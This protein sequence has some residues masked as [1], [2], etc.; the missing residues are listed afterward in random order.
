MPKAA[1]ARPPPTRQTR[2]KGRLNFLYPGWLPGTSTLWFQSE[3]SGYGH[4]Y[5]SDGGAARAV[6]AGKWEASDVEVG[7]DGRSFWFLCNRNWPG[8]YEC[9]RPAAPCAR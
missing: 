8:D 4:I 6:T 9:R 5:L 7:R 3:E 2:Q 1:L